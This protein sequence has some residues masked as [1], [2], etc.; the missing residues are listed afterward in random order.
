MRDKGSSKESPT[1]TNYRG[2]RV[3][4]SSSSSS[5]ESVKPPAKLGMFAKSK[6]AETE[7]VE[8]FTLN[9]R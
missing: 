5:P 7:D 3:E 4:R 6:M 9:S 2:K 8:T 1:T